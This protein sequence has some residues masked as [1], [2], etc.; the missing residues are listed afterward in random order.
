MTKNRTPT[1]VYLDPGMHPGLE[2]KG[3]I[4]Y[5][6]FP[7]PR[8]VLYTIGRHITTLSIIH[9]RRCHTWSHWVISITSHVTE[10]ICMWILLYVAFCTIMAIS[11]QKEARSRDYALLVF[12]MTS[13]ALYSAQYHRQHCTL[14][15]FEQFGALHMLVIKTADYYYETHLFGVTFHRILDII[16]KVVLFRSQSTG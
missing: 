16:L 1:P 12:R 11:R 15:S 2:V 8:Q 7:L 13:R 3:L 9:T 4:S 14:H 5:H 10:G 6:N